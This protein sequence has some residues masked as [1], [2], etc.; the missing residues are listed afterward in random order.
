MDCCLRQDS[1]NGQC[2]SMMH[3]LNLEFSSTDPKNLVQN[4]VAFNESLKG[5]GFREKSAVR[6]IFV[7]PHDVDSL[8]IRF[9]LTDRVEQRRAQDRV[10]PA[11]DRISDPAADHGN[12][13]RSACCGK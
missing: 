1:W 3:V 6:H 2:K 12:E 4:R 8:K 11:G 13:V 7:G 5:G 10:E 9:V